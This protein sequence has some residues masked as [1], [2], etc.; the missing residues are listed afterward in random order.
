MKDLLTGKVALIT[1]GGSGMGLASA[2]FFAEQGAKVVVADRNGDAA[3]RAALMI[4]DAG[5]TAQAV[6][7]D[8]TLDADARRIVDEALSHYGQL[9]CAFNNA[10]I[11]GTQIGMRGKS[12]T[13]WTEDAFD[14]I[15]SVNLIGV[16]R[17]MKFQIEQMI[18]QGGGS[19]VNTASIGGF[20]GVRGSCGYVASKHGVLGLTRSAA[21]EYAEQNIRINAVCPGVID[22][23]LGSE[24]MQGRT[25]GLLNVLPSGRIGQP[26]EVAAVA[27]FLVS[28]R[29][30]YLTGGSYLVDA[31]YLAA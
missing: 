15:V 12:L 18:K 16:W 17:C 25:D 20:V 6:T 14:A 23:P 31:A 29:A 26:T 13:D 2:R 27:A 11:H 21:I 28:D 22:T 1:G 30:S 7:A 3:A 24:A 19:I 8:I 10:G 9:N 4:A 5:G